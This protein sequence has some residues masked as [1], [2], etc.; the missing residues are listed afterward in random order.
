VLCELLAELAQKKRTGYS[1][2]ELAT[3]TSA[4]FFENASKLFEN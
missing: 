4:V 2:K 3:L 1:D